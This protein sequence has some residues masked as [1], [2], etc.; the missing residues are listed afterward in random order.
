MLIDS[1]AD[2][3]SRS[4]L[5]ALYPLHI[6]ASA[7]RADLLH[8]LIDSGADITATDVNGWS[9]LHWAARGRS[10]AHSDAAAVLIRAGALP[11]TLTNNLQT[12]LHIAANSAEAKVNPAASSVWLRGI[13]ATQVPGKMFE[14]LKEHGVPINAQ[15]SNGNTAL[16]VA[17]MKVSHQRAV[18]ASVLPCVGGRVC[19]RMSSHV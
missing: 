16:H 14:V 5:R 11:T 6:A 12:A 9:A 13:D 17:C 2:V 1:G 19:A 18:C 3:N 10:S 15:D 8:F 4:G 7:G